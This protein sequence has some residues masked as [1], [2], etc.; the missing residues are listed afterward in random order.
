MAFVANQAS[1]SRAKSSAG[2]SSK[3]GAKPD[4][5]AKAGGAKVKSNQAKRQRI[6]AELQ[7]LQQKVDDYVRTAL[8]IEECS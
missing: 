7:E 5:K 3:V 6:D 4:G 1:S 8:L 2:K